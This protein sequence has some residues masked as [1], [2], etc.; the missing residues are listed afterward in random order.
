MVDWYSKHPHASLR[1]NRLEFNSVTG[2][3]CWL[4]KSFAK[5]LSIMYI[6][7]SQVLN[8]RRRKNCKEIGFRLYTIL[9]KIWE[10]FGE[11][12]S[13]KYLLVWLCVSHLLQWNVTGY[14]FC[15]LM[16]SVTSLLTLIRLKPL[17]YMLSLPVS[18]EAIY[19][20][21]CMFYRSMNKFIDIRN[22]TF[23]LRSRS[24]FCVLYHRSW[25]QSSLAADAYLDR[26]PALHAYT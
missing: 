18:W 4:I 19:L 15:R 12:Q 2:A 26:I 25:L 24:Q 16:S 17:T 23:L 8:C 9:Y 3:Q 21:S 22:P 7:W 13:S 1:L 5:W 14:S 11:Q 10:C 6:W 20:L